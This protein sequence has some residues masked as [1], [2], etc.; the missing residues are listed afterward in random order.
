MSVP[1]KHNWGHRLF[2]TCKS[3]ETKP[4]VIDVIDVGAE[5]AGTPVNDTGAGGERKKKAKKSE[6]K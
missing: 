3:G 5:E 6:S 1:V 2:W 4:D